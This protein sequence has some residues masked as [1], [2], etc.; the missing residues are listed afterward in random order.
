[1][2]ETIALHPAA[3]WV[4]LKST[5]ADWAAADPALLKELLAQMALIRAFEEIVRRPNEQESVLRDMAVRCLAPG[6]V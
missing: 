2:P 1:M 3:P 5:E 6:A 4:E